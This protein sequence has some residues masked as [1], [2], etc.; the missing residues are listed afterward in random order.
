MDI[1]E[2]YQQEKRNDNFRV[3]HECAPPETLNADNVHVEGLDCLVMVLRAMYA[4]RILQSG[5]HQGTAEIAAMAV[6]NHLLEAFAF[7]SFDPDELTLTEAGRMQIFL[8][9][10]ELLRELTGGRPLTKANTSF[11]SLFSSDLMER[12]VWSHEIFRL[13][14]GVYPIGPN[15]DDPTTPRDNELIHWDCRYRNRS[16]E[17]CVNERF[18]PTYDDDDGTLMAVR[19]SSLPAFIRIRYD[20]SKGERWADEDVVEFDIRKS[21]GEKDP[22]SE[23]YTW[24]PD[25]GNERYGL[26]AAVFQ[27]INVHDTCVKTYNCVGQPYQ[28]DSDYHIL[29]HSW[30]FDGSRDGT[31]FLV[32]ARLPKRRVPQSQNQALE[33][34]SSPE[35][36]DVPEAMWDGAG[37]GKINYFDENEELLDTDT[38]SDVEMD[39]V[40]I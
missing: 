22:N 10:H 28:P 23:E 31:Y 35:V 13:V 21:G 8:I 33:K 19:Q 5:G 32:Y 40:Q 11:S 30:T 12:T 38:D 26:I 1:E 27:G 16:V 4:T 18:E 15:G 17:A 29:D 2:A 39:D 6:Q 14:A 7:N 37:R 36:D 24:N 25:Q 3:L 9:K 20:P 34:L